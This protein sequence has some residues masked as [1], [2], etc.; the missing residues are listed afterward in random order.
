MNFLLTLNKKCQGMTRI[1]NKISCKIMNG[2]KT[3]HGLSTYAGGH[4][5]KMVEKKV[6]MKEIK[7]KR[8]SEQ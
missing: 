2:I 8:R 4:V 1:K 7:K 6:G 5:L 3:C